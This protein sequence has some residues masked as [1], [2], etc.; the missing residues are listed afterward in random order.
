V[1]LI[2]LDALTELPKRAKKGKKAYVPVIDDVVELTDRELRAQLTD[3]SDLVVQRPL[4]P[5]LFR[6]EFSVADALQR[7]M[8]ADPIDNASVSE[9]VVDFMQRLCRIEP[10]VDEMG[11][12][13]AEAEL[14]LGGGAA[15]SVKR[16]ELFQTSLRR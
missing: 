2:D 8:A 9:D 4:P 3:A 14:E 15:W 6:A 1:P 5:P 10:V 16:T 12:T 11:H 13:P 7:P